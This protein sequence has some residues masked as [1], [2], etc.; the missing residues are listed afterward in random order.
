MIPINALYLNYESKN[1]LQYN[2]RKAE[3]QETYKKHLIKARLEKS[4]YRK[5]TK[6]A[7]QGKLVKNYLVTG[8]SANYCI[9]NTI[10]HYKT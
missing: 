7:K 9:V 6:L 3:K 1:G 5:D 8:D 2:A 10:T 4:Y